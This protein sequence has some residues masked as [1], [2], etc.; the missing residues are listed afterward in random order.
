MEIKKT[1]NITINGKPLQVEEGT[2]ILKACRLLNIEI[3]Q[4][5]YTPLHLANR[6]NIT[7]SCRVCVVEVKNRRNL[8][9]SCSTICTEG[10]EIYTN[11]QRVINARRTVVELLLSDHPSDCPTCAKNMHCK[12]QDLSYQMGIREM[13]YKG[14]MAE[15]NEYTTSLFPVRRNSAKCILCGNCV[16]VCDNIQTVNAL[17]AYDR[18]FVTQVGPAFNMALSETDCVACGQCVN[19]CPTGALIQNS[20]VDK[21]WKKLGDPKKKVVV[22][23][24]PSVRA[25]LGEEFGYRIGTAVTGKIPTALRALGFDGVYD[26][27]FGA[28]L[29]IVE[30]ATELVNRLQHNGKLPMFTSCCP[31]WITFVE[32]KFPEFIPNLSTCKSP[33][34]M[35]GAVIKTYIAKK[36]NVDPIDV[37][38]VAVMPCTAKK[39]EMNRPQLKEGEFRDVDYVL[40]TRDLARMIKEGGLNFDLLENSRFDNPLGESTGAA[41]IFGTSG[42]V[43][44]AAIRCAKYWLEGKCDEVEFTQLRG[45]NGIKVQEVE[46]NGTKLRLCAASG[47]GNARK[48]LDDIK[49]GKEQYDFVEIM[50]CPGGCINGGGQPIQSSKMSVNVVKSRSQALYSEDR[51]KL[52]RISAQNASVKELYSNYLGEFGGRLAHEHLHTK[53]INRKRKDF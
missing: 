10:M 31:G 17:T 51:S 21:V 6:H 34:S 29:T 2:T 39:D 52:H 14:E 35:Q 11:T 8:A 41:D 43:M 22:Q 23:V 33:M 53:Y 13:P 45:I 28:D 48:V 12:L 27:D 25:A 9:P 37:V 7:A 5:C 3:P 44:E 42:G 19:V 49:S 24:A 15:K 20:D 26:T 36:M 32:K 30:E 18:G 50:A 47:L 40:T 16:M 46:V 1:V 38:S 4:L